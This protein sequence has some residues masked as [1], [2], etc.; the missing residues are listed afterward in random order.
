M[1]P[2][3]TRRSGPAIVLGV[4]LVGL[5]L[6]L[7]VGRS[8]AAKGSDRVATASASPIYWKNYRKPATIEPTRININ[9]S[10]GFA[11]ATGLDQWQGWGTSRAVASGI[12]HLP[13]GT[14]SPTRDGSHCSR[15][16]IAGTSAAT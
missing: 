14:T 12:L 5:G 11:W 1:D 9:Y 3:A 13:P 16:G 6:L 15:S 7:L 2:L 10:T 4:A 8:A